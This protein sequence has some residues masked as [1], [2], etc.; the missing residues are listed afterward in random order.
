MTIPQI[1]VAVA[2]GVGF[3]L[4]FLALAGLFAYAAGRLTNVRPV[5][6]RR[7]RATHNPYVLGPCHGEPGHDCYEHQC[8]DQGCVDDY[9]FKDSHE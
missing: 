8:V 9:V 5:S 4:A 2:E 7:F 1:L 6:S 3:A